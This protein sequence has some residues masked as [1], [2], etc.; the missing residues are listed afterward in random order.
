MKKNRL[1]LYLLIGML[2]LGALACS[3]SFDTS[4]TTEAPAVEVPA[5]PADTQEEPAPAADTATDYVYDAF[6]ASDENGNNPT[7]VFQNDA[8]IY[9]IV[10][11][12]GAPSDTLLEAV[13]TAVEVEGEDPNLEITVTDTTVGENDTF[14]FNLTNDMLWPSGDYKVDLYVDGE[15]SRTLE[16]SIP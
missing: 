5:Q 4:A 16:F 12:D 11:V 15:L 2:A 8:V 10:I 14:T 6:L 1:A 13:W 3:F 7:T 9:F